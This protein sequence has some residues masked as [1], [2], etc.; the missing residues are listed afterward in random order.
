MESFFNEYP[1]VW[2][3]LYFT[4]AA[5]AYFL[6]TIIGIWRD[7]KWAMP[8]ALINFFFGWSGIGWII[9]LVMVFIGRRGPQAGFLN[10]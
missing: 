5:V 9:A 3:V 2:L 4:C 6:P 1:G 7:A 8:A 10:R